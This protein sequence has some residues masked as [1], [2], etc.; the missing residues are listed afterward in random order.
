MLDILVI[1]L[2]SFMTAYL[3]KVT[4]FNKKPPTKFTIWILSISI[5]ILALVGLML[6]SIFFYSSA[7]GVEESG[8]RKLKLFHLAPSLIAAY[9][10][11]KTLEPKKIT[12]IDPSKYKPNPSLVNFNSEE[13]IDRLRSNSYSPNMRDQAIIELQVRGYKVEKNGL[14]KDKKGSEVAHLTIR[15]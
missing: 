7:T 14:L 13:I 8:V 6:L 2:L 15:Q 4:L 1:S 9:I 12:D 3:L 11:F 10:F 5:F